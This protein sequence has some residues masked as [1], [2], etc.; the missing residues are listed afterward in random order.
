MTIFLL[1]FFSPLLG[2]P[3]PPVDYGAGIDTVD[4]ESGGNWLQKRV[5]WEDAQRLYEKVKDTLAHILEARLGFYEKRAQTTRDLN[6][7]FAEI[8]T[9]QG[10][11][12]DELSEM[13]KSLEDSSKPAHE[14]TDQERTLR[15]KLLEKKR[16]LEQL[17]ADL[18]ALAQVDT[19]LDTALEQMLQQINVAVGYDRHA[20]EMFKAIGQELDD[21][22][23]KHLFAQMETDL[24]NMEAILQYFQGAFSDYLN[25]TATKISDLRRASKANVDALQKE[26]VA[27]NK[28]LTEL[29]ERDRA[30]R[31]AQ[32]AR[33][34]TPRKPAKTSWVDNVSFLWEKPIEWGQTA[35][36]WI[37]SKF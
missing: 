7:F 12:M 27:L 25:K 33:E 26:G 6:V 1:L 21:V 3:E 32:E 34:R 20:W 22:K 11:L 29:Q 4:V 18:K 10:A 9:S 37:R 36:N 35:W 14:L 24:R 19:A 13:L 15:A 5:I 31:E 16:E 28:K 30:E 23:A 17:G 8:G 2:N